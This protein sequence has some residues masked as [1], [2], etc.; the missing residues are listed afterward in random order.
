[1]S[2]QEFVSNASEPK[3]ADSRRNWDDENMGRQ[4]TKR[5]SPGR[6]SLCQANFQYITPKAAL[7]SQGKI[8][9]MEFQMY[10][11]N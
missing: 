3:L 9:L 4:R 1:M 6:Q 10:R 7:N 2:Y 5:Q 11:L 8:F